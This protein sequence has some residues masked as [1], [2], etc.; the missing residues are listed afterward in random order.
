MESSLLTKHKDQIARKSFASMTHYNWVRKF[1][2][3]PQVMRVP[4]G[5]AAVDKE[6]KKLETIPAWKLEKVKTKKEV[7]LEAQRDKTKVHFAALMDICHI[8]NAELEPKLQKIQ[9][10]SRASW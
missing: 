2:P 3:V 8:K 7:I 10:Q 4:D 5:K 1:I 6:W 9:R